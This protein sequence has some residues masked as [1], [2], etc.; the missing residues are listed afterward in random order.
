M[1]PREI[2]DV[3]TLP[4][5]LQK[6]NMVQDVDSANDQSSS[7]ASDPDAVLSIDSGCS[8]RNI[9]EEPGFKRNANW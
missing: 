9:I 8:N 2:K 6:G 5:H 3:Q 4:K 7:S 1:D